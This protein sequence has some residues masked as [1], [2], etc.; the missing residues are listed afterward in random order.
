MSS[1]VTATSMIV[2]EFKR[3]TVP[4]TGYFSSASFCRRMP[5]LIP[6]S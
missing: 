1:W 2:E 5:S 4:L 6:A 3:G